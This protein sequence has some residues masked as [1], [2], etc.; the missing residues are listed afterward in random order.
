MSVDPLPGN[1]RTLRLV[2]SPATET[3]T[4][5]G[6]STGAQI[7]GVLKAHQAGLSA[8]NFCR[9]HGVSDATFGKWRS[10]SGGME[11][12]AAKR[13]KR[14]EDGN[15]RLRKV[16]AGSMMDVSTWRGRLGKNFSGPVQGDLP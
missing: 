11:V 5:R 1:V 14:L 3:E 12:S 8:M 15:T 2:C 6:R 4:K 16:P 10:T 7:I 13:L 9:K